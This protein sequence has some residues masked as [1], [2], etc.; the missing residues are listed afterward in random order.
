MPK[1]EVT[2]LT[3]ADEKAIGM[4]PYCVVYPPTDI[5]N[6]R[7]DGFGRLQFVT[8]KLPVESSTDTLQPV[9]PEHEYKAWTADEWKLYDGKGK[10]VESGS[11]GAGRVPFVVSY[12]ER[13]II[14]QFQGVSAINNIAYIN[15]EIFNLWSLLQD[16]MYRQC[17]NILT[18]PDSLL[19]DVDEQTGK[20]TIEIGTGNALPIGQGE[21][22][23]A[24]LAPPT[25][26]AQFLIQTLE[27]DVL[28]I[29]DEAKLKGGSASQTPSEQSGISKAFDFH[30]TNMLLAKKAQNLEDTERGIVDLWARHKG[31]ASVDFETSYART[32]DLTDATDE[33]DELTKFLNI[34]VPILETKRERLRRAMQ[35]LFSDASEEVKGIISDEIDSVEMGQAAPAASGAPGPAISSLAQRLGLGRAAA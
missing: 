1:P 6:W 25:D 28:R 26:P 18:L 9:G 32:F 22:P 7:F 4:E 13:S 23:G 34:P 15:R 27:K 19:A 29:Y 35:A 3:L 5:I 21:H 31:M 2:P 33:I 24:Y 10:L 30:E 11:H 12:N 20:R 14:N 8:V 16:F 17:L